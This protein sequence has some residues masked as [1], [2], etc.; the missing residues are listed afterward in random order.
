[1]TTPHDFDPRLLG[2]RCDICPLGPKGCLRDKSMEWTPVPNQHQHTTVAAVGDMPGLK[3][4]ERGFPFAN[5]QGA[6]GRWQNDALAPLGLKRSHIALLSSQLCTFPG[7]TSGARARQT[8]KVKKLRDTMAAAIMQQFRASGVKAAAA[9]RAAK[10]QVEEEIPDP[11]ACCRPALLREASRYPH[12]FALG[13]AASSAIARTTGGIKNLNG[14][15]LE[16]DLLP[17]EEALAP[18]WW[19]LRRDNGRLYRK[20]VP[21]FHPSFVDRAPAN[22]H[23]WRSALAKGLRWFHNR[24]QWLEPDSILL[25]PTP[26]EL[27]A[28]LEQ[29]A[30]YWVLDYETDGILSPFN[31]RCFAICIPDMKDG[32]PALPIETPDT[33]ARAVG[34]HVEKCAGGTGGLREDPDAE[35]GRY[36]SAYNEERIKETLRKAHTDG[37]TWVGHNL[38]GFDARVSKDW[39]GVWMT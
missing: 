39:L 22:V 2:A 25:Q 1:M 13:K 7:P 31:V 16:V 30:P 14:D 20:V 33:L 26:E 35:Y 17:A 29:E 24:L 6:G 10:A 11:T 27:D 12:V 15:L 34:V 21:A 18:P 23:R 38:I 28:F 5:A 9:K 32:R 19:P 37:R 4:V 8:A 36:Y 3:E